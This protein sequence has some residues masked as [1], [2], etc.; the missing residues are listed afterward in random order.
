MCYLTKTEFSA[1]SVKKYEME[2]L[3]TVNVMKMDISLISF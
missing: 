2:F 3:H 1:E